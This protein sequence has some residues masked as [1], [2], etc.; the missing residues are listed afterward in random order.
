[1]RKHLRTLGAA[2]AIIFATSCATRTTTVIDTGADIVRLDAP[3][4]AGKVSV[5]RDGVWH[6]AGKMTLPAGWFCGPGPEGG[7][8][9]E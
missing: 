4:K 2:G 6:S 7:F 9:P 8:A 5:F 1:M 3:V